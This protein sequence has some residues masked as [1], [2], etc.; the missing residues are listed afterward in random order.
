MT[1]FVSPFDLQI[2]LRRDI[3]SASF[4]QATLAVE[5]GCDIVRGYCRQLL[6]LIED[7][8]VEL[9]G[10]GSDALLLP[11]LP[12]RSVAEVIVRDRWGKNP[13]TLVVD[14]DYRVAT[15]GVLWRIG[16]VWLRGHTN[17]EV[18]YTH[19]YGT[20]DLGSGSGSIT[21]TLDMPASLK[22]VALSV[23]ARVFVAPD[24]GLGGIAGETIGTYSYTVSQNSSAA[25]LLTGV[26]KFVL[27]EFRLRGVA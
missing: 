3:T 13:E 19:G 22:Y 2:Y 5:S 14:T 17:V 8:V 1:A 7:D 4:D 21:E 6:D 12:V 20:L 23:A 26:E 15:G 27:D 16:D 9:D 18:T 24:A 11:E 25:S 10:T